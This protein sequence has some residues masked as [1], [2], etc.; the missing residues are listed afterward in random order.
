MAERGWLGQPS[1][2]R[3]ASHDAVLLW[4]AGHFAW[5]WLTGHKP[6]TSAIVAPLE[7]RPILCAQLPW[8][9]LHLL[10]LD[11]ADL[12]VHQRSKLLGQALIAFDC[13]CRDLIQWLGGK[14]SDARGDWDSAVATLK[15][16][17]D[18]PAPQGHPPTD[19][20][21]RHRICVE[22]VPTCSF[23][24]SW[25]SLSVACLSC[26]FLAGS[27]AALAPADPGAPS[28]H[29]PKPG[30]PGKTRRI[31]EFVSAPR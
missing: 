15:N 2:R 22:G 12:S 30:A 10:F 14:R 19:I 23:P 31:H 27:S 5:P 1:Q 3:S 21:L 6:R 9:S 11:R 25:P 28:S 26:L 24:G 7:P 16:S 8:A 4:L 18:A 29:A 13:N 20:N 17:R